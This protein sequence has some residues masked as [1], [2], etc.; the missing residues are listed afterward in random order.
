MLPRRGSCANGSQA[1][2]EGWNPS[3]SDVNAGAGKYGA[4][5]H[6]MDVSGL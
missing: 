6:E 4:C 2:S 3:D 5:C 1:N